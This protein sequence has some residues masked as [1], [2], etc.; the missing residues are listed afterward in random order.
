MHIFA[1]GSHLNSLFYRPDK[2]ADDQQM[3][4]LVQA[5]FDGDGILFINHLVYNLVRTLFGI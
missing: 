3:K 4:E 1:T 5:F 2:M